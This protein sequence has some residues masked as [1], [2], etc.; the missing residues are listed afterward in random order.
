MMFN[1]VERETFNL[2]VTQKAG[3]SLLFLFNKCFIKHC[4]TVQPSL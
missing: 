1:D 4:V 3:I 2:F